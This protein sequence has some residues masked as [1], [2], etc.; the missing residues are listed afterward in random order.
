MIVSTYY[1]SKWAQA[2]TNAILNPFY[3][4][5]CAQVTAI[6]IENPKCC[7]K[8]VYTAELAWPLDCTELRNRA[9]YLPVRR[10]SELNA[11][12]RW[13]SLSALVAPCLANYLPECPN[14]DNP[15]LSR[16]PRSWI[17]PRPTCFH[18]TKVCIGIACPVHHS[19]HPKECVGE[20]HAPYI[21]ASI[22]VNSLIRPWSSISGSTFR[23][24][25]TQ[26]GHEADSTPVPRNL[27]GSVPL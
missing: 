23:F 10:F 13:D 26:N 6:T 11:F 18:P 25:G 27:S 22:L 20:K 2:I 7:S 1:R 12:L 16:L 3:L 15:L 4:S 19:F 24:M 8:W 17:L 21:T 9:D 14:N 5:K